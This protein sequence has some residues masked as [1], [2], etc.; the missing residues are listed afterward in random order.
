MGWNDLIG[1]HIG[2]YEIIEELGRG[3]TARVYRAYQEAQQRYVAIKVL[4]NDAED[5]LGFVRRFQRE[6]DAVAQLNHPNIVAVYEAGEL[7]DLVFLVMQCVNGGTFRQRLGRPLPVGEACTAVIEVARALQHAHTRGI[8]HRDVKPSN[9]LIDSDNGGRIL[10][11]DFGIAKL[12]GMRGLTKSGT[13]I[14]TPEYMAPEQAEGREIDARADVY[15]LGC[16]L[17]EAL[18]GRAPFVGAAPVSVLYQQVHVKPDYIR[19]HNPEV[20]RELARI[21]DVALAK[22][23]EQRFS[24]ADSFALALHP[25]TSTREHGTLAHSAPGWTPGDVAAGRLDLRTGGRDDAATLSAGAQQPAGP[26]EAGPLSGVLPSTGLGVEG[27]DA[28]FPDDPEAHPERGASPFAGLR[29]PPGGAA[30]AYLAGSSLLPGMSL[31]GVPRAD[32]FAPDLAGPRPTV[33]L[34]VFGTPTRAPDTQALGLPLTPEGQL[35]MDQLM[36]QVEPTTV[37]ESES[38]EWTPP[39]DLPPYGEWTSSEEVSPYTAWEPAPQAN[40]YEPYFEPFQNV[41]DYPPYLTDDPELSQVPSLWGDVHQ[42]IAT[43]MLDPVTPPPIWRPDEV[44]A[45]ANTTRRRAPS[46][47]RPRTLAAAAVAVVLTLALISW[48]VVSALGIGIA[49]GVPRTTST[50]P[51]RQ[52]TSTPLPTVTPSPAPTATLTQQQQADQQAAADL[53]GV[54]IATRQM[55]GCA[56]SDNSTSFTRTDAIWVSLCVNQTSPSGQLSVKVEQASAVVTVIATV[57]AVPG[58]SYA[59]AYYAS[60]LPAGSYHIVISFQG[61]TAA[62]VPITIE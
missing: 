47:R 46:M 2:P 28:L 43:T 36:A 40:Q 21:V 41:G 19:T 12:A 3:G 6:L 16:V 23:P 57:T 33:P 37:E 45:P 60:N 32:Q 53:R 11:T 25:F 4:L 34:G 17:Y 22:Q 29:Q 7:E 55:S 48:A 26:G 54:V 52:P 49:N 1:R 59:W 10:L 24:S 8:V 15:S 42:A 20:P 50:G 13:T 38:L 58:H 14:G 27:L 61:G 44:E 30:G 31:P 18:A 39:P 35:D 9:M 5:R 56:A 51:A 62:D